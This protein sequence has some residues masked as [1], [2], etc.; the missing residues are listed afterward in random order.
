MRQGP[1]MDEVSYLVWLPA[2]EDRESSPE[3]LWA[4]GNPAK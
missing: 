4:N 1:G 3:W 2:P